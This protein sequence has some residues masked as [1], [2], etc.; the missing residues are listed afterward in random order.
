MSTKLIPGPPA[1]VRVVPGLSRKER[2]G[3]YIHR[4]LDKKLSALGVWVFRR[5]KGGIARPWNVDVLVL[6][7]MGRRSGRERRVLLQFF[8]DGDAMIVAA[9][10][11]GDAANPGWYVNLKAEPAAR[12]EVMGQTIAVR[13]EELPDEE[14][15]VWWKRI[16]ERAPAYERYT[17]A[18]NRRI[19]VLRL[20]PTA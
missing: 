16:E 8:P 17:R 13:A 3:L 9:A 10:N 14:A 2:I 4:G 12:V 20:F 18:T 15:A 7:T 11:G 5:T 6:T 1:P 19:P